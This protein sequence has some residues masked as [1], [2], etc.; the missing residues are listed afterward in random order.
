VAQ[1]TRRN[2]LG[3]AGTLSA[4]AA[5][6]GAGWAKAGA[7]AS[8]AGGEAGNRAFRMSLWP[9]KGL[10]NTRVQHVSSGLSLA[11]GDYSYSFGRPKFH[12]SSISHGA[13][14]ST[15]ISLQ[16]TALAGQLEV[17][18][19]FYLPHDR[20]WVEERITLT[21]HGPSP[22]DLH[23][24]RCA[25][26]LPVEL[27]GGEAVGDWA[28]FKFTAIPFRREPGGKRNQ[29]SDFTLGQILTQPFSSGLWSD[30]ATVTSAYA[31]EGWA[32]TDG[33]RGFL[34]TKYSPKGMEWSLLDRLPRKQGKAELR[35]GGYGIYRGNPEYGATLAPG[36]THRFGVTRL[37]A[38]E[39]G[40]LEGFYAF[41]AKMAARGHGCPADYNPPV[42]WNELYDNKLWW[43]PHDEQNDP[44]MRKKYYSLA[45][46]KEEAAKAQAIGCEALYQDPGWDTNFTSKIWDQARLGP[47]KAFTGMLKREY[48]LKSSLHTPLSGWGDPTSYPS[49]MY[50][51]EKSGKRLTWDAKVQGFVKSPLCGASRQYLEETARR[52]C[53][54]ARDGAAFFMFDGTQYHG[55]PGIFEYHGEC[56]DPGHGHPVPARREDHAQ[57]LCRLARMVHAQYPHVLIEM[58]DPV[59]GGNINHYTPIYYGHG[60]APEGEQFTQA[61]GFDSV[62]AFELMWQPMKDLLSGRSIALYYYSLAY[63]L[64]LYIHIDLRTDNSNA[65]VFWWNAST[66][67]HLGIGGTHKDPAVNTAHHQAM[68]AYRRLDAFFKRGRFYGIDEMTHVHIHPSEP[69]AVINA[70]NLEDHFVEREVRFVPQRYGLD[71]ERPLQ[72]EGVPSRRAHE[73]YILTFRIPARGHQLAEV[74]S[75]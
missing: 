3:R 52:L 4:A 29:Y 24:G 70:F 22:L 23:D 33:K 14:G 1:I 56:W 12:E 40:M 2:F 72:V 15:V 19:E 65:L 47:Y 17:L 55:L 42:H 67:R 6:Y 5:L 59:L 75:A 57:G 58:H 39:G 69:S 45:D 54:L 36:K 53:V 71:G 63:G 20:P 60:R 74:R 13:G 62:W 10:R 8:W 48:G 73:G 11:E 32:C 64:P 61:L 31:S 25:F 16:G 68:A 66:C 21:N 37:T 7:V 30:P 44:Q 41:R 46:M 28:R 34:L 43:L 50:R 18:Q 27:S 26:V 9:E 35:W 51:M 49:E 38:Y